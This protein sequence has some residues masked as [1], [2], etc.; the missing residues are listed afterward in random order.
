ML[1]P[2]NEKIFIQLLDDVEEADKKVFNF[3]GLKLVVANDTSGACKWQRLRPAVQNIERLETESEEKQIETKYKRQIS[4]LGLI[5][6]KIEHARTC[7]M[8]Q[9]L[10]LCNGK[11]F[12]KCCS[13][14][15]KQFLKSLN[16]KDTTAV[17]N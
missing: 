14:P 10:L 17:L 15:A 16:N 2:P 7:C 11:L 3:R 5:M 13:T 12:S 9:F 4:K 1:P 8:L 6:P